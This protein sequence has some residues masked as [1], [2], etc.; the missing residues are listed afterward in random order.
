MKKVYTIVLS[1]M[2]AI[3]ALAQDDTRI[4]IE[5]SDNSTQSIS[6]AD[7]SRI[8]FDNSN[9][10]FEQSNGS[11]TGC[12]MADIVRIATYTGE[13]SISDITTEKRELL[14]YISTD[15]IAVNCMT[16]S[17]IEIYNVSGSHILSTRLGADNGTISIAAL[18]KGI[19]L[20]RADGRTAKFIKR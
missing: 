20:L 6:F 4:V 1:L 16:G 3:P 9:V 11:I 10:K 13:T 12:D 5:K 15:E 19:Y 18:P 2:L 8:T 17:R 14:Q 7:L